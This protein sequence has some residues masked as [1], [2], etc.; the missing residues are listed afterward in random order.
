MSNS[1]ILKYRPQS[2]S[3]VVG[4]ASITKS[5]RGVLES[6]RSRAFML[7]GDAGLGKTTIA[8]LIAA[9]VGTDPAHQI[10]VDA[11]TFNGVEQMRGLTSTLQL[12]PMMG[13]SVT[14]IVDEAHA[15]SKA[16][17]QALLKTVEEPPAHAYWVFCTTDPSKVPTTIQSRCSKYHLNPVSQDKLYELLESV[18]KQ[19]QLKTDEDILGLVAK[20]AEGS[21]R[22]A[23]AMFGQVAECDD[24]KVAARLLKDFVLEE[25][26]AVIKLCRE[27][28]FGQPTWLKCVGMLK[29]LEGSNLEGARLQIL[30]YFSK[31]AV[32]AKTDRQAQRALAVLEAFSEPYPTNVTT[33]SPILLSLGKVLL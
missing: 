11:A 18:A 9:Q 29:G 27:L 20:K 15:L 2:W 4:Q 14:V 10:E 13:K 3:E 5:I 23:L 19:E 1:L 21:P 31:V 25:E 22:R 7:S 16:A 12:R 32:G 26:A 24:R 33:L 6:G 30:G 17:W 8:R 28:A